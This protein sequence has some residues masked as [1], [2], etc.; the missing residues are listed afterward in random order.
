MLRAMSA[1]ELHDFSSLIMLLIGQLAHEKVE[2]AHRKPPDLSC[3]PPTLGGTGTGSVLLDRN[4]TAQPARWRS[5]G[6]VR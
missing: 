5:L 1:E 2:A 3:C 4:E 6:G